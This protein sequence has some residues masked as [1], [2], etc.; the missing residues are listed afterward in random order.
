MCQVNLQGVSEV[1]SAA[2]GATLV[3]TVL[4]AIT[5]FSLHTSYGVAI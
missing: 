5:A 4:F 2:G 1:M 3:S